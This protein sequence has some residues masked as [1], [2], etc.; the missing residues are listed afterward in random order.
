[1]QARSHCILPWKVTIPVTNSIPYIFL[2]IYLQI[3]LL[4]CTG[5]DVAEYKG[6]T[7]VNHVIVYQTIKVCQYCNECVLI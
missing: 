7:T 4:F 6:Y 1:M 2:N 3:N 5:F